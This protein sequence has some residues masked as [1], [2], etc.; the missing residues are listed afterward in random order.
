MSSLAVLVYKR[1]RSIFLLPNDFT[2]FSKV[3]TRNIFTF[4]QPQPEL[5]LKLFLIFGQSESHC[6]YKV[7]L[8]T[9][10]CIIPHVWNT[11]LTFCGKKSENLGTVTI[12]MSY[13]AEINMFCG[14]SIIFS[15]P[16]ILQLR[17]FNIGNWIQHVY[18]KFF[19]NK[20]LDK[21][22]SKLKHS[23]TVYI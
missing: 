6:S 15:K 20:V 8:I 13:N 7:V 10:A 4:F 18:K 23:V 11:K 19:Y 3:S 1:R 12:R 5:V 17:K 2:R 14:F 16:R 9:I 22:S 21:N